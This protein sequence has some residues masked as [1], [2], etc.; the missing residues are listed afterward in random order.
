[1]LKK[2]IF[3]AGAAYL[4]RRFMGGRSSSMQPGYSRS[5]LG[6]GGWFGGS[7]WGRRGDD[8]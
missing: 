1:M 5:G 4:A 3:G 7:R 2:L 6:R 8:W